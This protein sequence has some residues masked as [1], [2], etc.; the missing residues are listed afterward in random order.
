MAGPTREAAAKLRELMTVNIRRALA[1]EEP[2][3]V[4]NGV[5]WHR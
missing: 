1:R 4:V 2:L 5:T 3:H